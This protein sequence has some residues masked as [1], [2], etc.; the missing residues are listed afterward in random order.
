VTEARRASGATHNA[1]QERQDMAPRGSTGLTGE[2]VA[3]LRDDLAAGRAPRVQIEGSQ[4][5]PGT[6]GIVKRVGD[7]AVDGEDFITVRVKINGVPDEL[8]FG[9]KE[10]S[11]GRGRPA[12]S[13]AK[14]A[15]AKAIPAKAAPAKG[16]AAK[17]APAKTPPPKAP[18]AK[19]S[20]P[21]KP[22][23]AKAT[24]RKPSRRAVPSA[25]VTITIRS[26]DASWSVSAQRGARS[27]LKNAA[28]NPGAVAAVAAL[29]DQPD[30]DAAVAAVNDTA[31][32]EAESRA[33][34]LRA[35]LAQIQAVLDSHRRP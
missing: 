34:Q 14:A 32:L 26:A 15:P 2:Q 16:T 1:E 9:P 22:A 3:T 4:F 6:A 28:V 33:D 29:L 27:V 8:R 5:A 30:L 31:R 18:V 7:P 17:T 20:Q 19:S 13:P 12:K 25:P 23:P 11:R 24:A 10:L 35:E 21:T